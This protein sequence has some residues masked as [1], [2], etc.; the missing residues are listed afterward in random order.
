MRMRKLAIWAG[1]LI[2]LACTPLSFGEEDS[3]KAALARRHARADEPTPTDDARVGPQG[4]T[5]A[6]RE[7]IARRHGL[8]AT[9]ASA[10]PRQV[11]PLAIWQSLVDGN[12]RFVTGERGDRDLVARR[13]I[14]V[15]SQHPEAIVLGC[16]DSRVSPEL[17]FDQGLGDLFVVRTAGNV[18]DAVALGSIEYA[19]EHL[20]SKLLIILG[21]EKCGAV[22][23][24]ASGQRMPTAGLEAIVGRIQPSL[25]ALGTAA[26]GRRVESL[27]VEANVRRSAAE[28][29]ATSPLLAAE[30]AAGR[31]TL[32]KVVYHL[33]TGEVVV[34]DGAERGVGLGRGRAAR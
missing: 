15:D 28:V 31:L 7:A 10:R 3:R 23:A 12:R 19:V 22:A 5:A 11:A 13:R 21:H 14:L 20:H 6:T 8:L 16:S 27:R 17:V 25:Q 18:A 30:V 24:A 1:A 9:D 33:E 4:L 32:V 29:L 34:L 2:A 26:S